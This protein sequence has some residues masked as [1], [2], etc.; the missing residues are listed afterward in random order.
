MRKSR[1]AEE[2][3]IGILKKHQAGLSAAEI[4]PQ[5]APAVGGRP[6]TDFR[7][8]ARSCAQANCRHNE[9]HGNE[10]AKTDLAGNLRGVAIAGDSLRG[11]T[12]HDANLR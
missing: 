5:P 9:C 2:Q 10:H 12:D 4:C 6:G 7:R 11:D 1:F 3:I 8:I